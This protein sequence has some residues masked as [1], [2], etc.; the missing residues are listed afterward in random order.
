MIMFA[1][2][3]KFSYVHMN[4]HES[5]TV[6]NYYTVSRTVALHTY[7][8]NVDYGTFTLYYNHNACH[9]GSNVTFCFL[10]RFSLTTDPGSVVCSAFV[11]IAPQ[12]RFPFNGKRESF[13]YNR[14]SCLSYSLRLDQVG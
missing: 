10:L 9:P 11:V 5:L 8:L 4:L 2:L 7:V 1:F 3:P 12:A 13:G 14:N 6:K